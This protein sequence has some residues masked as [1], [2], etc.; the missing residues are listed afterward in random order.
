MPETTIPKQG[1]PRWVLLLR[2]KDKQTSH[3]VLPWE[4]AK[5]RLDSGTDYVTWLEFPSER[6]AKRACRD[7]NADARAG[8]VPNPLGDLGR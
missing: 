1:D 3:H 6:E 8:K 7:Y 2:A 5:L 4:E